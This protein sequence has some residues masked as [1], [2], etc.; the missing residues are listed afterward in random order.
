MKVWLIAGLLSVAAVPVAAQLSIVS[1][2]R[3]PLDS[4]GK[5][6]APQFSPDGRTVYYTSDSYRGI[7]AYALDT[8]SVRQITDEPGAGYGFSLSGDGTRIAFRTTSYHEGLQT[9]A[10]E[11]VVADL[12]QHTTRTLGSGSDLTTPV[13]S[14]GNVVYG[15]GAK[16]VQIPVDG[17][18][19]AVEVLGIENTKIELFRNGTTELFDPF[20]GGSYIWPS[21]SPDKKLLVA[22]EVS[23]GTFVCDLQGEVLATL[24][25]RDS[26]SWTRDGRWLVYMDDRD[27]GHRTLSSDLYCISPEGT[28]VRQLTNTGNVT[29]M[30]PRCSPTENK[31]VCGTLEGEII[32]LE[33]REEGR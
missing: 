10:Q 27:D 4:Q 26:P 21:L 33:Y 5:W 9:R 15:S 31:I 13:F 32:V 20:G 11:I 17:A 7:W 8:K 29:E 6:G 30:Y 28:G 19:D 22:Y 24:G 18:P 2:E 12:Q 25:R 23:R 1:I 16:A 3:L 14:G